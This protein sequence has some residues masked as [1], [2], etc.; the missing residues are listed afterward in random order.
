MPL[1]LQPQNLSWSIIATVTLSLLAC[2]SSACGTNTSKNLIAPDSITTPGQWSTE[3][4]RFASQD[5]SGWFAKEGVIF[6]IDYKCDFDE[7][8]NGCVRLK[9]TNFYGTPINTIIDKEQIIVTPEM[10]IN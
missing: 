10:A 3:L 1:T 4:A 2:F 8:L 5:Q 6:D 9:V 7:R